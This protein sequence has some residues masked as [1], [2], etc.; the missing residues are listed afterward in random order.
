MRIK[1]F[2]TSISSLLFST[3]LHALPPSNIIA[4]CKDETP[5]DINVTMSELKRGGFHK[6]QDKTCE[7]QYQIHIDE[8]V[9][10]YGSCKSVGYFVADGKKINANDAANMSVHQGVKPGDLIPQVSNWWKINDKINDYL[11]VAGPISESGQG[12][13]HTQY[14]IIENALN[15]EKPEAYFLFFDKPGQ[16][17]KDEQD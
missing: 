8:K 14:Y 11:C 6:G 9:F 7:D 16:S 10:G 1:Y 13:A 12:A 2:I 3:N 5:Y 4:S 17:N 15:S